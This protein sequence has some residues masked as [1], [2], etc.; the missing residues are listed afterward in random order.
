MQFMS[1]FWSCLP[2]L[3]RIWPFGCPLCLF[4]VPLRG[5]LVPRLFP[6]GKE[7]V[8]F[9]KKMTLAKEIRCFIVLRGLSS[10]ACGACLLLLAYRYDSRRERAPLS[11]FSKGQSVSVISGQTFEEI[12]WTFSNGFDPL[13]AFPVVPILVLLNVWFCIE[14]SCA[15]T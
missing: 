15:R 3:E 4:D 14:C 2:N 10:V 12:R 8:T 1:V 13:G 7:Q 9:T 11:H 6:S 5:M